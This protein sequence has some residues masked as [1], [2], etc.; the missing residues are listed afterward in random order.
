MSGQGDRTAGPYHLWGL[1]KNGE[2]L[3]RR[4][5]DKDSYEGTDPVASL[6]DSKKVGEILRRKAVEFTW[7]DEERPNFCWAKEPIEKKGNKVW[8]K[9][10][11]NGVIGWAR[12]YGALHAGREGREERSINELAELL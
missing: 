1:H 3:A 11:A 9:S 6:K 5:Q 4:G 2:R 8:G 7:G 10:R 12:K